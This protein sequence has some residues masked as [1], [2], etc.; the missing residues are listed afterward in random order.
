M[1][2]GACIAFVAV[3]SVRVQVIGATV[4]APWF[5]APQYSVTIAESTPRLTNF[6]NV[7]AQSDPKG[8]FHKN[9]CFLC[10]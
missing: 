4:S 10:Y 8:N 7:T 9:F 1:F 5:T 6:L 2:Y 3:V